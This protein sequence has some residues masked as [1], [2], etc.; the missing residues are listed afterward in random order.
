MKRKSGTEEQILSILKEAAA[1]VPPKELCRNARHGRRHV[2]P[3]E[4]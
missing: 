2:L 1:G 4:A 3:V